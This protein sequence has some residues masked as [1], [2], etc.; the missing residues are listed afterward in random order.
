MPFNRYLKQVVYQFIFS[1]RFRQDNQ[2]VTEEFY[3]LQWL[4][5]VIAEVFFRSCKLHI[6]AVLWY[7]IWK[8][9]FLCGTMH[10]N[11][12]RVM[13]MAAKKVYAVR[14]GHKVGVFDTWEECKAAVDGFSGAEYKGFPTRAEAESYC[15]GEA[16]NGAKKGQAEVVTAY[17]QAGNDEPKPFKHS[18]TMA[19]DQLI[20]Y[21]DG[22]YE[23]SLLKYA[24]GCIF[25]MPDGTVYVEN[26]SGNNPESAKLRN[27]TGEMLG[28]MFAVRWAIKNGFRQ[29]ELRYDYEGVEKWVTGAW[30][31]KTELTQKY[32]QSMQMWSAQ[33]GIKFTKVAAHSNVFFNELADKQA[34]QALVDKEGIPAIRL[35]EEMEPWKG[36]D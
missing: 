27:V 5:Y 24:F 8:Y 13:C 25:L 10:K 7:D 31:S 6:S 21:V 36:Q 15:F 22:S 17:E 23:H 12:L 35:K 1:S 20:A 3:D 9:M 32:A 4:H 26:G 28:S 16:V 14:K 33:I 19:Q 18:E 29:I 34:K 11:K 2:K 30:K